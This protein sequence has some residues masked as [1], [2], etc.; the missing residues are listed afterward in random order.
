MYRFV[1]IHIPTGKT[2]V[3]MWDSFDHVGGYPSNEEF[4]QLVT[5]WNRQQPDV[6]A[7]CPLS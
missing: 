2:G 5:R 4:Y 3:T 1:W 7:Y 6:W